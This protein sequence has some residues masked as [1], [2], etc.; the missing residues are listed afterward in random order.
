MGSFFHMKE[1]GYEIKGK[2]PPLERY[3]F[4]LLDWRQWAG[5]KKVDVEVD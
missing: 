3:F 1:L 2:N 5:F 4:R